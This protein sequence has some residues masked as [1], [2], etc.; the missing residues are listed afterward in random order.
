MNTGKTAKIKC[1]AFALPVALCL[2]MLPLKLWATQQDHKVTIKRDAWGVPHIFADSLAD[3]SYGLGY[4]QAEDRLEQIYTN[5]REAVGRS[6][7]IKGT[8]S[9]EDDFQAHLAGHESV[10]KRRYLELPSEVREICESF[11]DGL[12]SF[13]A[14]HPDR[15]PTNAID[16]KPW[17]IAAL[18]RHVIF[19]W[20]LGAAKRKLGQRSKSFFFSNEWA[21][22]PERTADGAAL[23]LIDPHVELE[24][25]MRFYEFRLHAGGHDISGFA[26]SGSPFIGIGHNAF[27]GWACTTGGPDTT[28]IYVEQTDRTKPKSY[29]YEGAWREFSIETVRI[30]VKD[31]PTVVRDILHSHHGPIVLQEGTK[32]YAMACPYLGEIDF[33]TQNYRMM[34]ARNLREFDDALAMCQMMEQNLMYADVEGNI[35]YLRTGRVPVRPSGFDFSKPVS[36]ATQRSEWLGIHPMKDLVQLLNPS[37]GYLQNCNISPDV[38]ARGLKFDLSDFP[39]YIINTKLGSSNSR[40]R[41]AIELIEANPKLT[42]EGAMAIALDTHAEHC[43]RWQAVLAAAIRKSPP[44][45]AE[46]MK[47][48]NAVIEWNGNMEQDS[49]GASIYRGWR[50]LGEKQ[51]LALDSP[52]SKLIGVLTE[53]V[54]WMKNNSGGIELN[55]GQ[56]NRVEHGGRSWPFSGGNSGGGMTL[57]AM[58]STLEG[59]VFKG[60]WGQ[61]WT[62]LVQFKPGEVRSWSVTPFG[63][64]DDPSSGHFADQAEKLFSKSKMKPTWFNP[65]ELEGNVESTKVLA[66]V[67]R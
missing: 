6:S 51:K 31:S 1:E 42:I 61:N 13:E 54:A 26:P 56:V 11:Q 44:A 17:M 55:Y 45:D 66:V 64:S 5:Y 10:C 12:R 57:R 48:A 25:L 27:L 58:E 4:A 28:D 7:E 43:E 60:H 38:M 8:K 18:G 33:I 29:R 53:T 52:G 15:K 24:G 32:A 3:A 37:T 21:V 59:K 9:V 34:T 39:P 50:T 40:G 47:A 65:N 20:P 2:S 46:V 41:R 23:L 49:V 14:E 35:R 67:R 19:H 22:R 63:Q 30:E 36:G 16:L 62:T